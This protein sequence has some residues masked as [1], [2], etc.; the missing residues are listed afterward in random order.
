MVKACYHAQRDYATNR[1]SEHWGCENKSHL[2][3]N[4]AGFFRHKHIL[5]VVSFLF[6]T[7]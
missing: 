3:H 7:M 1:I 4:S 6:D 5:S 2:E